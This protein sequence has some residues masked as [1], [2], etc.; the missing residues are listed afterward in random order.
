MPMRA[1]LLTLTLLAL[2]APLRAELLADRDYKTL[3]PVQYTDSPGKIEVIEFFSYGCP[4]CNEFYP[5]VS[6][7]A[8]KLPKDIV[9]KRVP[10]GFGR[11][12]WINLAKAYYALE[13]TGELGRLDG[14]LFH[15]L[16]EERLPLFDEKSI[17]EWVGKQGGDASKFAAAFDSFGVNAKL[18]QAEQMAENYKVGAVPTL[19]VD[20]KY[21]VIGRTFQEILTNADQVIAKVRAERGRHTARAERR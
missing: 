9:F 16:H 12:P 2:C 11:A 4:H 6:A 8:T 10:T 20:G 19:A 5:L 13:A 1:C 21:V 17:R 18:G 14:A 15:A 7:W 3:D